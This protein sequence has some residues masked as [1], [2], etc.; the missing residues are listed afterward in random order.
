MQLNDREQLTA[1]LLANGVDLAQWGVGAAKRVD[2]LWQE[3]C[4]GEMELHGP[5]LLRVVGGVVQVVVRRGDA[6]LI[7]AAQVLRDGRVRRRNRPPA[8]K[9]RPGERYQ[10]AALRCL[11]EELGIAAAA[12]TLIEESYRYTQTTDDSPSY[13]GLL[14]RYTFHTIEAQV[15]SLPPNDFWTDETSAHD[16]VARHH[17]VWQPIGA[18]LEARPDRSG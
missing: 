18:D 12:I 13:P 4:D 3:L 1:V 15:A 17:W 16:L 8:D 14:S 7:E 5:P 10:A 11:A 9:L 2:D 6:I